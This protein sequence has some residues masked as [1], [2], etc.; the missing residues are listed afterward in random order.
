MIE[1][2]VLFKTGDIIKNLEHIFLIINIEDD[3]VYFVFLLDIHKGVK[4]LPVKWWENAQ[5]S[6]R[7]IY[8]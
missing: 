5:H 7:I 3:N 6:W 1:K 8:N 2:K 4:C